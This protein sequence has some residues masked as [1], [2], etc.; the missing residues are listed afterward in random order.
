MQCLGR[1]AV[2]TTGCSNSSSRAAWIPTRPDR[3][4]AR[5]RQHRCRISSTNNS[6]SL[7]A[8][9]VVAVVEQAD[10]NPTAAQQQPARTASP[11][12]SNAAG[13][14]N[15]GSQ[16]PKYKVC[17]TLQQLSITHSSPSSSTHPIHSVG[18]ALCKAPLTKCTSSVPSM[19]H[20]VGLSGWRHKAVLSPM[21]HGQVARLLPNRAP[22]TAVAWAESVLMPGHGLADGET[23][24]RT[25]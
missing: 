10:P 15:G 1:S 2:S 22:T 14:S 7:P 12:Q 3:A 17:D 6:N 16:E 9:D 13:G 4:N 24:D 8:R 5:R 23:Q 18:T 11:G 20:L 21:R 25:R 19:L